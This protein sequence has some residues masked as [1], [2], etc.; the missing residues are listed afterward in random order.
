[1]FER[2]SSVRG[3]IVIAIAFFISCRAEPP[4]LAPPSRVA[5]TEQRRRPTDDVASPTTPGELEVN[6]VSA[7]R[8]EL[9]WTRASDDVGVER[10]EVLRDGMPFTSGPDRTAADDGLAPAA[11][12]CYGVVAVDGAG[13]RSAAAGPICVETPDTAP[14]AA[15]SG[16]A[17]SARASTVV[18][19]AWDAASDDVAVRRYVVLR[20]GTPLATVMEPRHEDRAARPGARLCYEV[21]ALDAAGN[22][23]RAGGPA[24]AE[25]PDRAAPSV[26]ERLAAEPVSDRAVSLTWAASTDDAG[27]AGYEVLRDGAVVATTGAL[28]TRLDGLRPALEAC[29]TVRAFDRAGN[30]SAAGVPACACTP[31]LVPPS[32]PDDLVAIAPDEH[33]VAVRWSAATDDVAVTGYEVTRGER[34]VAQTAET[35]HAEAGLS[36]WTEYCYTVRALDAAGNRSATAGPACVRTPDTTPPVPPPALVARAATDRA[37]TVSWGE[38][39][40]EAGT[41]RYVVSRERVVVGETPAGTLQETALIPAREYCYTVV[42][43]DAAG[44][45]SRPAGPACG[46]TPDLTPPTAPGPALAHAS[47]ADQIALAWRA[48]DDDVGVAGYELALGGAVRAR[49]EGVFGTVSGLAPATEYCFDVRAFDAAGNRSRSASRACA[50]TAPAGTLPGPTHVRATPADDASVRLRWVPSPADGVVYA[51]YLEGNRRVGFTRDTDYLVAGMS[52]AKTACFE[53]SAVQGDERE[54]PRSLPAC[55]RPA[56]ETAAR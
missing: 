35:R 55:T 47:A 53:V 3:S 31:D 42:A 8:V 51:V 7:T 41:V 50:Q 46:R 23:S 43:W 48:A 30:R 10:Y 36:P 40:D 26:P 14:P 19:L 34:R 6:A 11:R 21:I 4:E 22:R 52:P 20:D 33:E 44:N 25:T 38:A 37:M 49:T 32:A 24:C 29:W 18:A 15:P 28:T 9:V 56:T 2:A 1:M 12:H 5:E 45:A 17:A 27:I 54:S 39:R 16:L 13:N